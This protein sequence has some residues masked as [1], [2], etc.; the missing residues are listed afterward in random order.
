MKLTPLESELL[1]FLSLGTQVAGKL[2][3]ANNP[4][5]AGIV[6]F[7]GALADHAT[8]VVNSG[9]PA[10]AQAATDIAAA[11]PVAAK[12]VETVTDHAAPAPA[13]A[14]A[15][16]SFIGTIATVAGDFIH[17]FSHSSGAVA[18]ISSTDSTP[19]VVVSVT[20]G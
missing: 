11:V 16:G 9:G 13:K 4:A 10:T 3:A 18:A 1:T 15:L 2:V 20:E 5:Y 6:A 7:I 8:T 14:A 19:P 12:T 17:F